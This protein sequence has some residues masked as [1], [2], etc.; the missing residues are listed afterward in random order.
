MAGIAHRKA[1][2]GVLRPGRQEPGTMQPAHIADLG[3]ERA[4]LVE[5]I[6]LAGFAGPRRGQDAFEVAIDVTREAQDGHDASIRVAHR[7]LDP[8]QRACPEERLRGNQPGV[9]SVRPD[10]LRAAGEDLCELRRRCPRLCTQ[11]ADFRKRRCDDASVAI[12]GV[13]RDDVLAAQEGRESAAPG[14]YLVAPAM[15][16]DVRAA[17]AAR[18]IRGQRRKVRVTRPSLAIR[19]PL[20]DEYFE[21]LG[22]GIEQ[23]GQPLRAQVMQRSLD[24]H[25]HPRRRGGDRGA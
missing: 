25:V 8:S 16:A 21:R 19:P 4:A 14:G 17:G 7:R 13:D 24:S 5:C 22:L 10:E 23:R 12:H 6:G 1:E 11:A 2:R 15:F 18:K 20:G 3:Q 9:G